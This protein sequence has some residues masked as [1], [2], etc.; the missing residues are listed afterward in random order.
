MVT[1][2]RSGTN[3]YGRVDLIV[4][5]QFTS[6]VPKD[7]SIRLKQSNPKTLD[8]LSQLADQYLAA[9]NEKLSSK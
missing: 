4:H 8:E 1:V 3:H 6:S 5:G 2:G 9:R 7:L